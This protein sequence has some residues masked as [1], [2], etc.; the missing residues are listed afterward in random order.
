MSNPI[1]VVPERAMVFIDAMNLYE[2]MAAL[3][4]NT[5]IDYYK[6]S[7]KLAGPQRRLIRAYVY[8]G[9][10]DQ[11]REPGK[12]AAQMNFLVKCNGCHLSLS[13]HVHLFLEVGF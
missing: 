9:T 6:L 5:N 4:T 11:T 8:T 12:Y 10:Y 1:G 2:S 3:K 7:I 13:R